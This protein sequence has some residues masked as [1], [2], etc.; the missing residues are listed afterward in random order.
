[1]QEL[2][3]E[4]LKASSEESKLVQAHRMSPTASAVIDRG[5]EI[6]VV[7]DPVPMNVIPSYQSRI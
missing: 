6:D 7:T 4:L 3:Q 2:H 5:W 1:M